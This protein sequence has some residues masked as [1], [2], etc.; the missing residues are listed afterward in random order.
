MTEMCAGVSDAK[1]R[2]TWEVLE[3][4]FYALPVGIH[5]CISQS[6]PPAKLTQLILRSCML[7]SSLGAD[8]WLCEKC[9][10]AKPADQVIFHE[11]KKLGV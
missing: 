6:D 5:V 11:V 1:I 3:T 4:P 7:P 2:E 10:K 9:G 8:T